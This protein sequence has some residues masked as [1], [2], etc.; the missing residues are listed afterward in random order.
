MNENKKYMYGML[1]DY[2]YYCN[3]HGYIKFDMWYEGDFDN[4]E[5]ESLF[6]EMREHV[7]AI[8]GLLFLGK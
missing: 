5:Q 7:D 6:Y 1:K 8:A 2:L 3:H 4:T